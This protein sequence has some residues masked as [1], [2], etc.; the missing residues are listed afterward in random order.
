MGTS[1]DSINE[2]GKRDTAL[3]N[4]CAN[5]RRRPGSLSHRGTLLDSKVS[6]EIKTLP[7]RPIYMSL[8][9]ERPGI[10]SRQMVQPTTGRL[11]AEANMQTCCS[12]EVG[13][14]TYCAEI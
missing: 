7:L 14:K 5:F 4:G 13:R 12:S 11:D 10:I 3:V 1:Q 9:Q 6:V 8:R 2:H